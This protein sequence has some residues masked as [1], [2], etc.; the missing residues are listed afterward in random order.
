MFLDPKKTE[1]TGDTHPTGRVP[2]FVDIQ[3]VEDQR[4][5][6]YWFFC[7]YNP[8]LP[9]SHEGDWERVIVETRNDA[10]IRVRFGAHTRLKAIRRRR[11]LTFESAILPGIDR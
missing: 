3:D 4:H 9:Y 10:I 8:S 6:H 11:V 5:F 1:L 7:G 2:A